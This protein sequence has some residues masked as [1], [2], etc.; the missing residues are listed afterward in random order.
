M[1]MLMF[2]GNDNWFTTDLHM[3]WIEIHT[4]TISLAFWIIFQD[5]ATLCMYYAQ[6]TKGNLNIALFGCAKNEFVC[7]ML[8]NLNEYE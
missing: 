2:N 6:P 1:A 4:E 7:C 8:Y 3:T 5:G